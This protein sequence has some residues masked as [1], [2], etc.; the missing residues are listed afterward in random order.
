MEWLIDLIGGSSTAHTIFLLALVIAVGTLLGKIKVAGVSLGIT[1]ILF[2]GI[3]ASH[4]N[5][6]VNEDVLHFIKDFGLIL[7]V[8]SIGLQVGPGFFSSFKKGGLKLNG[9]AAMIVLLGVL[10]AYGISSVTGTSLTTMV[11]IMSGAVTNTPGLGAAQQAYTDV[12]GLQDQTISMGYAVAYPLGVVGLIIT[13]ILLRKIFRIDPDA[14]NRK[15]E[16]ERQCDPLAT[17]TASV[18]VHNMNV[19]GR[20]VVDIREMME[21][22]FV[23]SRIKGPDGDVALADSQ[24]VVNEGDI[25]YVVAAAKD[26]EM[27]VNFLGTKVEL[28]PEDWN[29]KASK[30]VSRRVILTKPQFNGRYLGDL[31]LRTDFGVNVTRVNR[32]GVDL[33]AS[34]NL[35]LQMG[36][37]LTIVGEEMQLQDVSRLLGNSMKRLR[38][39]NIVTLFVGI[40][41]GVL[42]GSIPFYF[43]SIPQPVKLGLAGGSLVVAILIGRFGPHFRIVTY[44]TMSAS[45]MLREVGIS[46]FLAA[47]GLGAGEG[48]VETLVNGGYIWI[49][50]GFIIT[51]VPPLIIGIIARKWLK[52]DYFNLMGLISGSHTSP[53]TLSYISN[54]SPNDIPA[55]GYTTVYPLSMFLRVLAAQILILIAV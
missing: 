17:R 54:N 53:M 1:F 37:R 20:K 11:G 43:G 10:I 44:T 55:V 16:E 30:L 18:K 12:T 2:V 51:V 4:F 42:V 36:D 41:L 47:V 39:P 8:F 35:E 33:A 9:L 32:A 24:C 52:V 5:L 13:M 14:E 28:S 6:R 38:E 29:D 34:P 7:F 49:L 48:F 46:L 22:N 27:V 3:L 26:I 25:I 40:F 31:K 23:I 45:L 50:Y 15:L 19:C 21:A